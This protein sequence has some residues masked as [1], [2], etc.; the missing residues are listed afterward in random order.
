M[1][2]THGNVPPGCPA[3]ACCPIELSP[4]SVAVRY[5]DPVSVNCSTSDSDY[6]GMGWEVSQGGTGLL[7]VRHLTWSV[8]RLTQWKISPMCYLSSSRRLKAQCSDTLKVV[9]YSKSF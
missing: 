9:V 1:P 7:P 3:G 8:D 5:G 4:P 6:D 2:C